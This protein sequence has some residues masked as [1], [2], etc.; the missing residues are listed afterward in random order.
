MFSIRIL[1]PQ[2]PIVHVGVPHT[3]VALDLDIVIDDLVDLLH[4]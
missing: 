1:K 3:F 4:C 2:R